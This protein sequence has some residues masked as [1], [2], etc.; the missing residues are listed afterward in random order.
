LILNIENEEKAFSIYLAEISDIPI[1]WR[2]DLTLKRVSA[3]TDDSTTP[4]L[5]GKN[6]TFF[7]DLF[8]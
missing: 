4:V 7:S 8:D 1:K 6:S 5:S 2:R 3:T